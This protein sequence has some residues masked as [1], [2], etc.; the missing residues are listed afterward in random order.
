MNHRQRLARAF[1]QLADTLA[2][3][4]DEHSYLQDFCRHHVELLDI[5]AAEVHLGDDA[6]SLRVAAASGAFGVRGELP[7]S[8]RHDSPARRAVI[9]GGQVHVCDL[10]VAGPVWPRFVPA[11]IRLGY[12]AVHSFPLR[13]RTQVVGAV[14]VYRMRPGALPPD[15]VATAQE[16]ADAATIGLVQH[17]TRQQAEVRVAQLQGALD[18]RVIIEQAKGILAERWAM[19]VDDAFEQMRSFARPRRL[20][21][22]DVASSIVRGSDYVRDGTIR[23]G[24]GVGGLAAVSVPFPARP[25]V[26]DPVAGNANGD[27]NTNGDGNANGISMGIGKA[28][29]A[30]TAMG[31]AMGVGTAVAEASAPS[32]IVGPGGSQMSGN[33]S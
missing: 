25:R 28:K 26:A 24:S 33:S 9:T 30:G 20:R 27:S 18:S 2:A 32:G 4:F 1:I 22:A 12:A 5:D 17:R 21:L 7:A 29:G 15:Q 14:S 13:L 11:A 31:T 8:D 16:L 6:D 10:R 23:E 3:D 19:D